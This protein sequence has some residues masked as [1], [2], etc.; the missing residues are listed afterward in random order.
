MNPSAARPGH[1]TTLQWTG[2][3]SRFLSFESASGAR[4]AAQRRSVM[5][6]RSLSITRQAGGLRLTLLW[7]A[8]ANYVCF[9]RDGNAVESG[10][11]ADEPCF[12]AASRL[13][14][15]Y[16]GSP[17]FGR[18]ALMSAGVNAVSSALHAGSRPQDLVMA[19]AFLFLAA[20]TEAGM[21]N[22]KRVM[23]Q[24][25][26]AAPRPAGERAKP[27]EPKPARPWWRRWG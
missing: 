1:N 4:P 24:H 2:R 13:A 5:L 20:P 8:T 19:P 9:D 7:Y 23:D 25:A 6:R 18:M 27:E 12:A 22:A 11:L 15:R 10:R 3:A 16:A 21:A 26:A 14:A 17:G